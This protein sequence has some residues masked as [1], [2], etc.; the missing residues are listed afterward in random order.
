M[1]LLTGD[2]VVD[3]AGLEESFPSSIT[4]TRTS[5]EDYK[6]RQLNVWIDGARVAT[7][8][9]GDSVS[10]ELTP[11]PHRLRVSNTLVWKTIDFVAGPH[12]QIFFEALNR[13]GLGSLFFLMAL[14]AGP[15]YLTVRRMC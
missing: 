12:E 8:L 14:G 3:F 6:S 10:L 13:L 15:L 4:I 1:P 2:A 7:L 11:G 5:E 9:W